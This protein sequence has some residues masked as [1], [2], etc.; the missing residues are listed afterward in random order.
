MFYLFFWVLKIKRY[1]CVVHWAQV[2]DVNKPWSAV[3]FERDGTF[4][5]ISFG[6]ALNIKTSNY[7]R[8]AVIKF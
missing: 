6:D 3:I 4:V 8:F 5:L 1:G 2:S 7:S